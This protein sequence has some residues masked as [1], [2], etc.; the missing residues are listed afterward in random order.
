MEN[1]S[2]K[3]AGTFVRTLA[4]HFETLALISSLA[5]TCL[6][7]LV[8]HPA[9]FTFITPVSSLSS[10]QCFLFWIALVSTIA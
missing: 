6:V 2:E 10:A 9:Y 4:P 8:S 5:R 3:G 7:S 1:V